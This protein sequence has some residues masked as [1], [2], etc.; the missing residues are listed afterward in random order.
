M[1]KERY[2]NS[3]IVSRVRI[4]W[5]ATT[6]KEKERV[7][8]IMDKVFLQIT[9]EESS[10]TYYVTTYTID[11]LVLFR[12]KFSSKLGGRNLFKAITWWIIK[13]FICII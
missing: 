4:K 9:L 7:W 12:T 11:S 3:F 2:G 10:L 5:I 6:K 8:R 1:H 13:S